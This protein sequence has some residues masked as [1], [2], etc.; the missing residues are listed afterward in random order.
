[1]DKPMKRRD[2]SGLSREDIS[3]RPQCDF[4]TRKVCDG[5]HRLG[6]HNY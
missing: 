4:E 3:R 6:R 1:M 5:I 2:G